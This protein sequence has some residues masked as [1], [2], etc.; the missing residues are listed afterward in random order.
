[1]KARLEYDNRF[2][3]FQVFDQLGIPRYSGPSSYLA[4][5]CLQK[6]VGVDKRIDEL[7]LC[8]PEEIML[9]EEEVK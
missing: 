1:M 8:R 4:I 6:T 7:N 5:L 9:V 2:G 3:F